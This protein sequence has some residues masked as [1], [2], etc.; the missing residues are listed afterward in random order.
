LVLLKK[1]IIGLSKE[2]E[3]TFGQHL[4]YFSLV[5]WI[6]CSGWKWQF[7]GGVKISV[8]LWHVKWGMGIKAMKRNGP[9]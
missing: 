5:L 4:E 7:I 1:R 2:G 8:I 9:L 3:M 6:G